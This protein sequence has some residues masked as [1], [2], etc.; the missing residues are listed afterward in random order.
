ML[1]I[2]D[3]LKNSKECRKLIIKMVSKAQASHVGS[4]LS[5]VDIL[6]VL[7]G[8][9]LN[10]N[11]KD[12]TNELRDRFIFSKGHA[13]TALYS[14]LAVNNI[15]SKDFLEEYCCNNGKFFGHPS[16]FSTPAIEFSTGS[17]GH[18]LSVA[19]GIALVA[20]N[21]RK[22]FR[23]FILMGDGECNEGQ[24]WEAA[25]FASHHKLEN[26]IAIIDYNNL[27][28]FGYTNEVISMEPFRA[29]WESFGWNVREIDG[30][31]ITDIYNTMTSLPFSEGKPNLVIAHTIKGKGISFME[32][33]LEWHYKSPNED[34]TLKALEEIEKNEISIY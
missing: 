8:G 9:I 33:R 23:T 25:M 7:Y 31:N 29:K 22:N 28:G 14:I 6:T 19:I 20:K 24:V 10:I 2:E 34:Q 30:H 21:E 26:L 1:N 5:V 3:L 13:C 12:I 27:Q 17:L 15:I 18:G 11:S 16:S 4:A 32:D